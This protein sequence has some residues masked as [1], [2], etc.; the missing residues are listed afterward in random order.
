MWFVTLV[1]FRK[2][3][4]KAA[5]D[6]QTARFKDAEK[7]GFKIHHA[8]WTIGQYDAIIV[9]EAPDL[10]TVMRVGIGAADNAQTE[11]LAAVSRDEAITW[12]T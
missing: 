1:K 10:K 12:L 4:T 5:A 3:M 8:F 9:A 11:T 2:K 6:E 7:L